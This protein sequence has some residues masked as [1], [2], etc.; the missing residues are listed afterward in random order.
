MFVADET[1]PQHRAATGRTLTLHW[2]EVGRLW[3]QEM[4]GEAD[5]MTV[6]S[7]GRV[8]TA[9]LVW[10]LEEKKGQRLT[11]HLTANNLLTNKC[12]VIMVILY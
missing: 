1:P 9:Q 5:H 8:E 7:T 4:L 6:H 10:H 3:L 12:V 11:V 2:Q